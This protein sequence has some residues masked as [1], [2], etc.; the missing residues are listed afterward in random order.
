MVLGPLRYLGTIFLDGPQG[1]VPPTSRIISP[2]LGLTWADQIE[3][4]RQTFRRIKDLFVAL[5]SHS[6]QFSLITLHSKVGR[7]GIGT[8]C[9]IE[10]RFTPI[11]ITGTG[12]LTTTPTGCAGVRSA[13]YDG[14]VCCGSAISCCSVQATCDS[15]QGR[16]RTDRTDRDTTHLRFRQKMVCRVI[17]GAESLSSIGTA[18]SELKPRAF[19]RNHFARL[20]AVFWS[21]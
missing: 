18:V 6:R 12:C 7:Y 5:Y 8:L 4:A 13:T 21:Q 16:S 20:K 1:L 9:P 3:D 17:W 14:G 15:T 10:M 2:A 19:S 11:P